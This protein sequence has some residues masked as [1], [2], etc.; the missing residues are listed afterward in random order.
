MKLVFD[1]EQ[2]LDHSQRVKSEA[3]QRRARQQFIFGYSEGFSKKIN[4][5]RIHQYNLKRPNWHA[6]EQPVSLTF[7]YTELIIKLR[8]H[9]GVYI[10]LTA[11]DKLNVPSKSPR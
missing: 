11:S 7:L 3:F 4:Q 5:I 2:K 6:L 10:C 8:I 1:L 9:Q